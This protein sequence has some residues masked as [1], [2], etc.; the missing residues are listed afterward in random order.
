MKRRRH[1][2]SRKGLERRLECIGERGN[3]FLAGCFQ[4][5]DGSVVDLKLYGVLKQQRFWR[6]ESGD[7]R[8]ERPGGSH[9]RRPSK[10]DPRRILGRES[11][12]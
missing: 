8:R 6:I 1:P 4:E 11:I 7:G 10:C 9:T 3:I 12:I 2:I 5:V